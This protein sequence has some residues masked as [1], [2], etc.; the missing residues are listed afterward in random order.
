[1]QGVGFAVLV[2]SAAL[3]FNCRESLAVD[4]LTPARLG[5]GEQSLQQLIQF[6]S[7]RGDAAISI[8]CGARLAAD[9]EFLD[10]YCWGFDNRK[11]YYIREIQ[12]VADDARALPATLNGENKAVWLQYSVE[13]KKVGDDKSIKVYPNWGFNREAY[14]TDYISPQLYNAPKRSMRCRKDMS[15]TVSMQIDEAGAIHDPEIVS[16]KASDKC[17]EKLSEFIQHAKYIPASVDG[18]PVPVKYV[19][20]WFQSSDRWTGRGK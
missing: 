9:G 3:L 18:K 1:M 13:F 14:G 12:K 4:D 10:T 20:F 16:G 5:D 15:F 11:F 8:L 19:D 7:W 2:L 6:P 17:R